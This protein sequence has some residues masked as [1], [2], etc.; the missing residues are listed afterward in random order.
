LLKRI[1]RASL[2]SDA[3]I[4]PIYIDD[5]LVQIEV[6]SG[7]NTYLVSCLDDLFRCTCDDFINRGVNRE[8]GSFLCKHC[9]S[10]INFLMNTEPRLIEA[11]IKVNEESVATVS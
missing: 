9:L 5:E 7:A 3:N 10:V 6:K 8:E 1:K 2:I 11:M 4:T